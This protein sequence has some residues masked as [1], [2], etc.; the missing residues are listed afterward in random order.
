MFDNGRMRDNPQAILNEH[1]PPKPTRSYRPHEP[2]IPVAVRMVWE[3]D[4][5]EELPGYAT[6]WDKDHV[7]VELWRLQDERLVGVLGVWVAPEDVRRI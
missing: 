6:R 4:R 7:F 5:T 2:G 3:K 1:R